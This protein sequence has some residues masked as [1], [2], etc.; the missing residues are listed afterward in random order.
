M[1][2][3]VKEYVLKREGSVRLRRGRIITNHCAERATHHKILIEEMEAG[4]STPP[5]P[6]LN[7][8]FLVGG[9]ELLECYRSING[10][11]E[12][13]KHFDSVT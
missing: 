2:T 9:L 4:T 3:E 7:T 6:Y 11:T 13:R 12:I 8:H 1:V 10:H 5:L